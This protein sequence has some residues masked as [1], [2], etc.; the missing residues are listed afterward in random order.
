MVFT[1]PPD[2]PVCS[3]LFPRILRKYPSA[4]KLLS[5]PHCSEP[6]EA[7][8]FLLLV[9][10]VS[11]DDQTSY[12]VLSFLCMAGGLASPHIHTFPRYTSLHQ[13][14]TGVTPASSRFL[15]PPLIFIPIS[16]TAAHR[17]W[18]PVL[19]TKHKHTVYM[20]LEVGFIYL[21]TSLS[22]CP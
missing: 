15:T 3:S 22:F 7:K 19:S 17:G 1:S 9:L 13:L 16:A 8:T 18:S 21:N 12:H 5:V 6:P 14:V 10:L 11:Q 4:P 20:L 2:F